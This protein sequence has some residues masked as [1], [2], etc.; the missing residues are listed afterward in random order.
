MKHLLLQ[1]AITLVLFSIFHFFVY[2]GIISNYIEDDVNILYGRKKWKNRKQNKNFL[3]KLFFLDVKAYIIKWHYVCFWINTA[4]CV[5]LL[6]FLFLAEIYGRGIYSH[7]ALVSIA[8]Y[9][10]SAFLPS[11]TFWPL[12]RSWNRKTNRGEYRRHRNKYKR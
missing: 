6:V 2:V 3:Q 9:D 11:L 12:N 1:V 4:S 8:V 5:P 10:L 7:L